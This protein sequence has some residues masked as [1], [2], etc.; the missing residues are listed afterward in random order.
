[1]IRSRAI[2][3]VGRP[4]DEKVDRRSMHAAI[5]RYTIAQEAS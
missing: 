5:P 3:D 1:M 2:V 4:Q